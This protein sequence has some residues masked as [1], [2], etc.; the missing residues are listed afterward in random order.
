MTK[1]WSNETNREER[2][3][4]GRLMLKYNLSSAYQGHPLLTQPWKGLLNAALCCPAVGAC[5]D[6]QLAMGGVFLSSKG[7]ALFLA[8]AMYLILLFSQSN[9]TSDKKL[10]SKLIKDALPSL[11]VIEKD[12][13]KSHHPL[14]GQ[15]VRS[16][17]NVE[18]SQIKATQIQTMSDISFLSVKI[19]P[20]NKSKWNNVKRRYLCHS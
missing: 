1:A 6:W 19:T 3:S 18:K 12:L 11:F 9:W 20:W 8:P 2:P 15:V 16:K 5:F 14:N 7:P 13:N 4:K 10:V 17:E